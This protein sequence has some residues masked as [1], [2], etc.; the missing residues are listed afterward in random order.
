MKI[1][2]DAYASNSYIRKI[3]QIDFRVY[4]GIYVHDRRQHHQ[5]HLNIDPPDE[6]RSDGG[7]EEAVGLMVT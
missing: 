1:K 5:R 7:W 3:T 2:L 6:S 4:V